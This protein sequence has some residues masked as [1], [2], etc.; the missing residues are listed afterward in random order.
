MKQIPGF[1]DLQ[2]NGYKGVD[3]SD[4]TLTTE[5]CAH[6]CQALLARGTAAFL[7]TVITSD[8]ATYRRN[9]AILADI[10]ED[11]AF[12]G[13]VL[14]IHAEGPFISK[15]PGAVG[16]HNPAYVKRPS[17][18]FFEKMQG[19]AKGHIKL[20]TLAAEVKGAEELTRELVKQG[21]VVSLGHQMA[22]YEDLTRLADAG[23]VGMTHLG[24]GMPNQVDRH[25]NP[26][27]AGLAEDRLVAMMIA[28]GHHLPDFVVKTILQ[29][30]GVGTTIVT[31]DASP[32]AGCKPGVYQALGNRAVLRPDGLLHNPDKQCMVGSSFT[33]LECIN[34]LLA[35]RLLTGREV[36]RVGFT[37]PLKLLKM[38]AASINSDVSVQYDKKNNQFTILNK[39]KR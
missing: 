2:V 14:G 25:Y 34:W 22:S 17:L 20:V 12:K 37:N 13:K 32:I 27:L 39:G 11:E 15:L 1:I 30:K 19:W 28:D 29:A 38:R 26:L 23:A 24:N 33:M 8:E 35:Q 31:S 16:A 4:N 9:L 18:K 6:A 10:I 7:P 3:F 36:I 5:S 21:I